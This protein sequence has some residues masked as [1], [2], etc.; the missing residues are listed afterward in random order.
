MRPK[1][2]YVIG[3]DPGVKTGVAVWDRLYRRFELLKTLTIIDAIELLRQY[4]SIPENQNQNQNRNQ[5]Q[6]L[7][8]L[9][10]KRKI[11]RNSFPKP[12]LGRG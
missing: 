6:L 10:L 3:I 11:Q 4:N 1:F 8:K 7:Q 2:R 12:L 9:Q 5:N